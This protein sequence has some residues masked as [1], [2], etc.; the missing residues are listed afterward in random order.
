MFRSVVLDK[1]P[2][3]KLLRRLFS[4]FLMTLIIEADLPNDL[5]Q[6]HLPSAVAAR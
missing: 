1:T 5:A 6:F 4:E 2:G 3:V